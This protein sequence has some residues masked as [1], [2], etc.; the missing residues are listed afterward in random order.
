MCRLQQCRNVQEVAKAF[1]LK[2]FIPH[3]LEHT[4]I[5]KASKKPGAFSLL[6]NFSLMFPTW[7]TASVP[8]GL[9]ESLKSLW[10]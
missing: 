3:S 6:G 9:A 10:S 1:I 7:E 8:C 4:F 5:A 2:E